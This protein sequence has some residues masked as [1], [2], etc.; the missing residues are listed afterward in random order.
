MSNLPTNLCESHAAITTFR[1]SLTHHFLCR[2]ST[3]ADEA[4]YICFDGPS[5]ASGGLIDSP[6]SCGSAVHASCLRKWIAI[7]GSRQCSI[8]R[9]KLPIEFAARSPYLILQVVRHMRGLHWTGEREYVVGFGAAPLGGSVAAAAADSAVQRWNPGYVENVIIGSG[10]ECHLSLPDPSLSRRHSCLSYDGTHF[11]V[12]DLHSSAGTYVRALSHV[13]LPHNRQEHFKMGRT[14][15]SIDILSQAPLITAPS[16]GSSSQLRHST[17]ATHGVGGLAWLRGGRRSTQVS[18]FHART[19]SSTS[20][21]SRQLRTA[22]STPIT[23]G[24]APVSSAVSTIGV[25]GSSFEGSSF[26]LSPHTA[27]SQSRNSSD[28]GLTFGRSMGTQPTHVTYQGTHVTYQGSTN[29]GTANITQGDARG[30]TMVHSADLA[31]V[32]AEH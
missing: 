6:C 12:E 25:G 16:S 31:Y 20:P 4:C 19:V 7:K 24:V 2:E 14:A 21:Q 29:T 8:C 22:S 23:S 17:P 32:T 30:M 1:L 13:Q 3:K 26:A 28:S 11:K 15:L 5:E 9:S 10:P 18:P 27:G